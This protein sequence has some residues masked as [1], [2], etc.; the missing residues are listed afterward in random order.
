MCAGGGSRAFTVDPAADFCSRRSCWMRSLTVLPVG[1]ED[2]RE[3][4]AS[5]VDD[6]REGCAGLLG[7]EYW[8][9]ALFFG[10]R[11]LRNGSVKMA[12]T[13]GL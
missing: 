2:V 13:P 8:M 7:L 1:E 5:L 6:E 9:G 3:W 4:D 12:K 11:D 10:M